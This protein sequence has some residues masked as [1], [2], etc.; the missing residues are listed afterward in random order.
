[1]RLFIVIRLLVI[2]VP[3]FIIYNKLL[4]ILIN[5]KNFTINYSI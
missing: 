3:V 5:P 1:M 4:M 2:Y